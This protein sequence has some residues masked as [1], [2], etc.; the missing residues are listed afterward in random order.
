MKDGRAIS[1]K[2]NSPISK[3]HFIIVLSQ[4]CDISSEHEKYIELATAKLVRPGKETQSLQGARNLRKLQLPVNGEYWEVDSSLISVIPKSVLEDDSSLK[5]KDMLDD[6][7]KEILVQWRINRYARKPFPDQFNRALMDR[8]GET[9][10]YGFFI[11]YRD[12]IIDVFAFVDPPD[13][14]EAEKYQVS[15]TIVLSADCTEGDV[16]PLK[17]EIKPH[18]EKLNESD[19]CLCMLQADG[20]TGRHKDL[21][22]VEPVCLPSDFSFEDANCMRR[23][24][25]DFLCWE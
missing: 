12:K 23:L 10:L 18:I 13:D 9:G 17:K 2:R 15:L 14:E 5:P 24:T 4:D 20:E 8:E 19:N 16:G 21:T 1:D 11:Q 7:S 6:T 22:N 3:D 25:L